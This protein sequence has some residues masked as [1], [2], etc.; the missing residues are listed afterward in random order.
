[1]NIAG[2]FRVTRLT[3]VKKQQE[4]GDTT[5]FLFEP[6]KPLVHKAGQHGLWILPGFRGFHPFTVSSAPSEPYV[7]VTTHVRPQS[8]YK[9]RLNQLKPGEK[10]TFLGPVLD[11]TFQSGVDHYI[12]LAQ[13]IGVTPFRSMLV[14]A[15]HDSLLASTTLIHV[16]NPE[17]TF[18][19]LTEKLATAAYYPT[20]PA[21]FTGVVTDTKSDAATYYIS[22]SPRFVGA[23][24]QTLKRLNVK[25]HHIRTDSFL[26][27]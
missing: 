23:T 6:S 1:M 15:H 18:R 17:H 8:R 21:E 16:D 22:G 25:P 11:F 9:Q 7:A 24:K 10:M 20:S 5:T 4:H 27:Y 14:Q 13:G 3:F 2:F 12:F 26:G 19:A